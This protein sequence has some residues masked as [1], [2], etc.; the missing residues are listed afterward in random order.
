MKILFTI[1]LFFFWSSIS[2][3]IRPEYSGMWYNHDQRGH[4]LSLEVLDADRTVGFWYLYDRAGDPFWLFLD[5]VNTG[6]RVH[7]TAYHFSGMVMDEWNPATNTRT[8]YGEVTVEFTDCNNATLNAYVSESSAWVDPIPL[9]RLS[10]IAGLECHGPEP[11]PLTMAQLEGH[12]SVRHGQAYPWTTY[13]TVVGPDGTYSYGGQNEMQLCA[14]SGQI[15]TDEG[16]SPTLSITY[17]SSEWCTP[18]ETPVTK[19]GNYYENYIF[20]IYDFEL[21]KPDCESRGQVIVFPS[22]PEDSELCLDSR[23]IIFWRD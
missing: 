7:M 22:C 6:N 13:G 2:A 9:E 15:T 5:G 23:E 19:S 4:G 20:C 8:E 21:M 18:G 3:E 10:H 11:G 14:Y 12:W 1:M 17:T 16:D